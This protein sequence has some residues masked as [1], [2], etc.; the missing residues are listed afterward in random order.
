[1][2]LD[3]AVLER[4]PLNPG[5]R[6]DSWRDAASDDLRVGPQAGSIEPVAQPPDDPLLERN[7]ELAWFRDRIAA[8]RDAAASG[9]CVLLSGEAGGGK[10]SD[11]LDRLP[12][13]LAAAVRS[14]RQTPEV[15]AG[16]LAMLRERRTPA[17]LVI[18]HRGRLG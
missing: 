3:G 16:V 10:T 2:T 4:T 17:V 11:L 1:V 9:G 8:L 5:A 18:E 7:T 15:L 12:L 13:S 6:R 14:G